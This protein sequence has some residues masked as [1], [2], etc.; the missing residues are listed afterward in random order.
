[1]D[2]RALG[3]DL[4]KNL[5]HIHGVMG[6]AGQSSSRSKKSSS[7]QGAIHNRSKFSLRSWITNRVRFRKASQ[8]RLIC[9]A[10]EA[11]NHAIWHGTIRTALKDMK[12]D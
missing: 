5:F 2:V 1:M 7:D 4:E 9:A 8:I 6:K 3:I 10:P 12:E 11:P